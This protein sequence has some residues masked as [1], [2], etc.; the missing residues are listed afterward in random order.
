MVVRAFDDSDEIPDSENP[1]VLERE[2]QLFLTESWDYLCNQFARGGA[3]QY[4]LHLQLKMPN[5]SG[6]WKQYHYIYFCPRKI[7]WEDLIFP[8]PANRIS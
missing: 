3:F 7:Q 6:E 5:R 4:G 8:V 2:Y 1:D